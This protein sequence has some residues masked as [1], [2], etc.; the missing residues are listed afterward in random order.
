MATM[1]SPKNTASALPRY[2][3]PLECTFHEVSRSVCTRK[4]CA[5]AVAVIAG[6]R[7]GGE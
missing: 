4:W 6:P 5:L 1:A 3:Q 7:S 2:V